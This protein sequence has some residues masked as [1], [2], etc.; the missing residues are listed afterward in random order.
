[1]NKLVSYRY[2]P[3][4]ID[5]GQAIAHAQE[6][7]QNKEIWQ[8]LRSVDTFADS[9]RCEYKSYAMAEMSLWGV[10]CALGIPMYVLVNAARVERKF[11]ERYGL[12]RMDYERLIVGLDANKE[13]YGDE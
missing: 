9:R 4:R 2:Q 10:A 3:Y 11:Y 7:M 5:W 6:Y 13:E 1:M 12:K 8:K